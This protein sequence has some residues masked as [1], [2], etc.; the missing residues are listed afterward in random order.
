MTRDKSFYTDFFKHMTLI[1]LSSIV[2]FGVSL[3][4]NV[5]L[6]MYSEAALS[7][8]TLC[9]QYQFLLHQM[10]LVGTA[11]GL[12]V[13][14]SQYFGK[15]QKKKIF[16]I[17]SVGIIASLS[18]AA[19]L[20]IVTTV[21][22]RECISIFLI[23]DSAATGMIIEEALSY[24]RIIRFTY[25]L[26]ALTYTLLAMLRSM[27]ITHT[28]LICSVGALLT[29]IFLNYLLIFGKFGAPRLGVV[30]AAIA[31]LTA[32]VV[33]LLIVLLYIY[34]KRH[35]ISQ[36]KKITFSLN[37]LLS[38]DYI[39]LTFPLLLS[40]G[41][42]GIATGIQTVILGHLGAMAIAANSVAI[43][44]FQF[45][46]VTN[47]G[48]CNA[49]AV[50]I[51]KTVGEGKPKKVREYGNTLQVLFLLN[52]LLVGAVLFFSKDFILQFYVLDAATKQLARDFIIVLSVS[53]VGT[54]YQ[55]PALGGIVRGAGD[56]SFVFKND[57]I[58]VC[59]IVL[60]SAYIAAFVLNLSPVV[61]Y[62][63]LKSDQV[64]KCF[65][66]LVKVNRYKFIKQLTR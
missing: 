55:Y 53:V 24:I 58:F 54:A 25:P 16:E 40:S 22:P 50:I 66:A 35:V 65:V 31:T 59:L 47:G 4:D 10:I 28:A 63:C 21:A 64:L 39:C 38:K 13:I 9:N 30:G 60:P 44:L 41:L 18:I 12:A 23:E 62:C 7:G 56:T 14:C 5:M 2:T 6:G 42:W 19:V 32:R 37:R 36:D 34:K 46:A 26:F 43:T 49:A 29:N 51:G 3:A 8:V 1:A 45:V 48:S 17:T 20:F 61:V 33:E 52:G 15:N 11:E 27:Q 57:I